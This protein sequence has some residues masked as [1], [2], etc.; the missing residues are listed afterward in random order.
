MDGQT[1]SWAG[2]VSKRRDRPSR[3]DLAI[4][5]KYTRLTLQSGTPSFPIWA[6][7]LKLYSFRRSSCS[8]DCRGVVA[9]CRSNGDEAVDVVWRRYDRLEGM[10]AAPA[11]L[12]GDGRHS[13]NASEVKVATDGRSDQ[14]AVE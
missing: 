2:V 9:L 13:G 10:A 3:E 7:Q 5:T 6:Q 8:S 14:H 11:K 4:G 1:T 12:E